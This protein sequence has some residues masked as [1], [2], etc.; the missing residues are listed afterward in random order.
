MFGNF[1]P[2]QTMLDRLREEQQ[3][4][5]HALE[6]EDEG[7]LKDFVVISF[8]L[9]CFVLFDVSLNARGFICTSQT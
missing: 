9:R 6:V 7:H 5:R 3:R 2:Q 4:L 8:L 1:S